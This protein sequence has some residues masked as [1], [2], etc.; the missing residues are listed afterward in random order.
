MV[1]S[2]RAGVAASQIDS[3][4]ALLRHPQRSH[5]PH[6]LRYCAV[7]QGMSISYTPEMIDISIFE[8]KLLFRGI[9]NRNYSFE[10][11]IGNRRGIRVT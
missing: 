11:H 9:L 7:I 4:L 2:P 10:I 3:V 1:R 6:G 8:I 5:L